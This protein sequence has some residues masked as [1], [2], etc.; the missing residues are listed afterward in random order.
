M[1]KET[2]VFWALELGKMDTK[3]QKV[4]RNKRILELWSWVK[5]IQKD[6]KVIRN[7]RKN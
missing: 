5:G 4:I 3:G 6:R 7:K 2:K 1:S